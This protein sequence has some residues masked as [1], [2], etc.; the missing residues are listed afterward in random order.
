MF[1]GKEIAYLKL[2]RLAR[3]A[4]V[5]KDIQPD[6]V[7]VGF[8]FDGKFF[9]V[10][11]HHPMVTRK[12]KN[13]KGGNAHVALVVDDPVSLNPWNPRGVRVYGVAEIVD[14]DGMFGVGTYLR[15]T[16]T[17]SWS[18]NIEALRSPTKTLH[19]NQSHLLNE[20]RDE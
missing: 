11:G 20:A 14:R 19:A 8:E 2:Q 9:C 16:P 13:V 5:G 17:V 6:V 18:W 7:P 1:T 15:V 3:I 4:T 12:Y 10:G